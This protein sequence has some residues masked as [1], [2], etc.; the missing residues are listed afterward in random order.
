MVRFLG[1]WLPGGIAAKLKFVFLRIPVAHLARFDEELITNVE[2]AVH[3]SVFGA[4]SLLHLHMQTGFAL[5]GCGQPLLDLRGPGASVRPD[6]HQ[7][8]L[9][10]P[11]PPPLW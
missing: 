11:L 5:Q 8:A 1:A 7:R 4:Y 9:V 6:A 2:M 10:Y 3:R